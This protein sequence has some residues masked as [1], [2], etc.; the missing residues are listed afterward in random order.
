MRIKGNMASVQSNIDFYLKLSSLGNIDTIQDLRNHYFN[1]FLNEERS[2]AN[3]LLEEKRELE[4]RKAEELSKLNEIENEISDLDKGIEESIIEDE[5]T[6]D[7]SDIFSNEFFN[8]TKDNE[9]NEVEYVSHGIYLE[10]VD[11]SES[12]EE[13]SSKSSERITPSQGF[14]E[15]GVFLDDVELEDSIPKDE[16]IE[17]AF[18]DEEIDNFNEDVFEEEDDV[19]VTIEDTFDD[20][21]EDAF[22]D[23]EYNNFEEDT[24]DE[25][26]ESAF[27][28]PDEDTSDEDEL[29]RGFSEFESTKGNTE[30]AFEDTKEE[31]TF[32]EEV[33]DFSEDFLEGNTSEEINVEPLPNLEVSKVEEPMEIPDDIRVFLRQHPN[34]EVSY[35]AQFYP[36]KEINKQIKLGRIYKKKC[37]LLN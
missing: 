8:D 16:D 33:E 14:V 36:M 34:S 12:N 29:E 22:E 23:E 35:V 32:V 21:F 20:A 26:I 7:D 31:S 13:V 15:H 18:E 4:K 6:Y 2:Q 25:D 17:D 30:D 27:E 1:I 19:E 37:K 3:L 11:T 10:D 28:D 9:N 24:S 5:D